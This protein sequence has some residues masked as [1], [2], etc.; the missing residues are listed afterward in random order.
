MLPFQAQEIHPGLW[1]GTWPP[2]GPWLA[3]S[4]F[5]TLVLCAYEYQP[6]FRFPPQLLPLVGLRSPNPWPGV[7][8]VYAPNDDDIV[9]PPPREVLRQAV[10]AGRTVAERLS[11]KR[12]VLT[13]C[14]QGRNRSGLVSALGLFFHLH[15]PGATAARIV[16]LRRANGLRNPIF[17]G[18]L[19]RLHHRDETVTAQPPTVQ[20]NLHRVAAVGAPEPGFV[21]PPEFL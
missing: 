15:V 13:T 7:E 14:W 18:L 21:I 4:G 11:Q 12:K 10:Q 3:K 8:V 5:S 17:V 20:E 2:P 9:R 6:P 16:Q 1:Q 19:N